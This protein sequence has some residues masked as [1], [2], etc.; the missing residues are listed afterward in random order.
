MKIVVIFL[1]GSPLVYLTTTQI[2]DIFLLGGLAWKTSGK[3]GL[4]SYI[5]EG[6][7]RID[8]QTEFQCSAFASAYVLRH[9]GKDTSGI[10]LYTKMSHKMKNGYVYPKGIKVLL[11]CYGIRVHYCRGN[12]STLKQELQKG[13]PVIVMIRVWKDKDW[14]HYVPVVGY[15]EEYFFVA[16]SLPDLV[17]CQGNSYNRKIA[18]TEFLQ[19]WN[20]AMIKM[21]FY[22][23][24][25]FSY[26]DK[27]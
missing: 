2:V 22:R 9:F 14:L 23:N 7:N 18:N 21:P 12:L 19:L 27:V 20:T 11:R 8:I 4:S 24:T 5:V 1:I 10:K 17:N 26:T 25:Y 15:D 16:E 3:S 6:K 13:H